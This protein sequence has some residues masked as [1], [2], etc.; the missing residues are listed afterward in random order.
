MEILKIK[1]RRIVERVMGRCGKQETLDDIDINDVFIRCLDTYEV[2]ENERP[3][4]IHSY[5]EI[6][7][8]LQE[9][10]PNQE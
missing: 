2:A 10:D 3:A 7:Q 4:L 9:E 5:K 6:I 1:N 8:H